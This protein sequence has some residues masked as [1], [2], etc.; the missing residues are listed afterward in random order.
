MTHEVI[1]TFGFPFIQKV[2]TTHPQLFVV[3]YFQQIPIIS[4]FWTSYINS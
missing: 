1:S 2:S 3:F 4:T